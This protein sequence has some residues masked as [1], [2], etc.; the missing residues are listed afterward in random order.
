MAWTL[1][2]KSFSF[3]SI[4][5]NSYQW[6]LGIYS[7]PWPILSIL[8]LVRNFCSIFG[9]RRVCRYQGVNQNLYI[10]KEQTTICVRNEHRYV[11]LVDP[12]LIHGITRFVTRLTRWVS[13]MEQELFT[14]LEHLSSPLVFS[15]THVTRSQKLRSI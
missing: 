14:L 11:P 2:S 12:F 3:L 4:Q 8:N 6:K 15:G 10:E 7:T 9:I 13:L 5:E 1:R